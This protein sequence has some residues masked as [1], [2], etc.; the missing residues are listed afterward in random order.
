MNNLYYTKNSDKNFY[1]KYQSDTNCGSFALNIEEWYD[2]HDCFDE[3]GNDFATDIYEVTE[4][5]VYTTEQ[6]LKRAKAGI[7][8]DFYEEIYFIDSFDEY[9]E[10]ENEEL[11]AFRV[12]IETFGSNYYV[13]TDFHFRVFRDG[14]WQEK[15]GCGP[16]EDYIDLEPDKPWELYNWL[17]DSDIVYFVHKLG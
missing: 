13:S 7:A 17:Y 8:K 3:E 15:C 9:E 1:K 12:G 14:R 10:K 6:L 2:P 11:I 4:D 16:V 5:T